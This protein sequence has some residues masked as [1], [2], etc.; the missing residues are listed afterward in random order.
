MF[1][2]N[3]VAI[4]SAEHGEDVVLSAELGV[5]SLDIA[6]GELADLLDF[7]PVENGAV[8]FLPAAE[9]RSDRDPHDL[10]CAILIRLVSEPN[11]NR[12][13]VIAK[14]VAVEVSVK[15]EREQAW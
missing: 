11:G 6:R 3:Q 7:D 2:G 9:A 5:F 13:P 15:I 4:D 8:K 10:A 12:L 1:G 14:Y